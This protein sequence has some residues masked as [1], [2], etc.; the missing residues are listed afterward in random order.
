MREAVRA[1]VTHNFLKKKK[2]VLKQRGGRKKQKKRNARTAPERFT[3]SSVRLL[4]VSNKTQGENVRRT[5]SML[6]ST[7]NVLFTLMIW[8]VEK[9]FMRP[10][11][12][13]KTAGLHYTL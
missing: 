5:Q 13:V 7:A 11:P 12:C 10:F 3:D 6:K 2:K 4:G 1:E 9:I 8:A